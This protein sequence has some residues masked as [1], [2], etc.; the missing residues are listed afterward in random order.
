MTTTTPPAAPVDSALVWTTIHHGFLAIFGAGAFVHLGLALWAPQTYEP[1]ADAALFGWVRDGWQD[2]FLANPTFWALLLA[3]GELTIAVLLVVSRRAGYVA[4]I[5]FHLALMLFGWG[6]WLWA[7][8]ALGFAV[9][10]AVH[11]FRLAG[12]AVI[13]AT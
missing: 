10:A 1:F 2:I 12:R 6:F 5:A 7:V 9:P 4:V 3:A 11:E 13:P 8:P